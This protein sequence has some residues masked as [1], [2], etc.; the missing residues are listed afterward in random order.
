DGQAR[1][2]DRRGGGYLLRLT[3]QAAHDSLGRRCEPDAEETVAGRRSE[4]GG[5]RDAAR[6]EAVMFDPCGDFLLGAV[7]CPG[8]DPLDAVLLVYRKLRGWRFGGA[9]DR[10]RGR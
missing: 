4:T 3:S 6:C 10:V 9:P 1:R 8:E 5:G 2:D 7:S